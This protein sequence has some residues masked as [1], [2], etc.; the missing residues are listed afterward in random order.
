M[1]FPEKLSYVEV[2]FSRER[3]GEVLRAVGCFRLFHPDE[4][5]EGVNEELHR[6]INLLSLVKE[7]SELL[8]I[9]LEERQEKGESL[10]EIEELLKPIVREVDT[11]RKLKEEVDKKRRTILMADEV[12]EALREVSLRELSGK[13]SF[14]GFSAGFL[15]ERN[16]EAFLITAR[17]ENLFPVYSRVSRGSYAFA[18]FYPERETSKELLS[19]FS[20]ITVPPEAFSEAFRKELREKERELKELKEKIGKL[21]GENL[22]R[23]YRKLLYLLNLLKIES[24]VVKEGEKLTIRGWIPERLKEK[25]KEALKPLNAEVIFKPAGE[26]PPTL[27][28]TP[29]F[30]KP[31]EEAITGYSYPSYYDIN[32]VVPF[33]IT[34]LLFFGVMFGD[35]GHGIMLFLFGI[36]VERKNRVAGRLLSLAGVSS[37]LFGF[38]YGSVFGRELLKPILFSPMERVGE[39]LILS[40]LVGVLSVSLGMA[41]N[42][43]VRAKR[44]ERVNLLF[45]EGG[46][47]SLLIYWFAVGVAVKAFVLKVSVKLDLIILFVLLFISF[48]FTLHRTRQPGQSAVE[49]LRSFLENLVNTLSFMRL[50]A[51]A[52]AHGA[53]FFSVF[54]IADLLG[55]LK[56]GSLLYWL[57]VVLGNLLVVALEG[58]IVTIQALRLNY[59]E[60]FSKFYVGGGRPFKPVVLEES[61]EDS[62][63]AVAPSSNSLRGLR[64]G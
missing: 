36:Y 47:L 8:D 41:L 56:G 50:G 54:T 7:L 2:A 19:S 55:K 9:S 5:F 32:P 16:L 27:L 59:Y 6:A 28:R 17:A 29:P 20:A 22:K 37:F 26:N 14:I 15:P 18:L 42:A 39:L 40:L 31:V 64:R 11:L 48:L 13:L 45:G 24:F 43:V 51:F 12:E 63:K 38:L 62:L 35:V 34:F 60:F 1:L 58:L 52:L 30:L 53:L 21:Y 33:L 46:L 3:K 49:S 44:G 57:F 4:R 10:E 23:A 61:C 25:F